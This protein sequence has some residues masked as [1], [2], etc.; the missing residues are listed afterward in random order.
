MLAF[1][2]VACNKKPEACI[3]LTASSVQVGVPVTATDCSK[4]SFNN[5]L[6]FGDGARYTD[7]EGQTHTYYSP[8]TYVIEM[9]AISKKGNKSESAS[10]SLSVTSP[11]AAS[12]KGQW[13]LSTVTTH[14][15]LE[16]DP[17]IDLFDI[18]TIKTEEFN[19]L[20]TI[21]DKNILV[22]HISD[23]YFIFEN[24]LPFAFT[25][26]S[27]V[28]GNASYKIVRHSAS[29]MVWQGYYFKGFKLIYLSK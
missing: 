14:E 6:D 1:S 18:P 20:I 21:D 3:E 9:K 27:I 2:L 15:Q 13:K 17:L 16:L 24:E 22:T 7:T 25:D 12:I 26:G 28:A 11:A 29:N 8:G 5:T 10:Q 4:N 23:N 19:E